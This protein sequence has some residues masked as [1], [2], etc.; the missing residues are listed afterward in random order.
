[1]AA[2]YNCYF[3]A[4]EKMLELDDKII[5]NHRDDYNYILPYFPPIDTNFTKGFKTDLDF[6]FEKSKVAL[7]KHKN[8][9]WIAE[10]Y[11]I[12][13]K[14]KWYENKLD[15]AIYVHK[16]VIAK[17]SDLVGR[18]FAQISLLR[19]YLFQNDENQADDEYLELQKQKIYPKNTLD[20]NLACIEY[21]YQKRGFEEMLPHLKSAL[22]LEKKKDQRSRLHFIIAQI[23]QRNEN[24]KIAYNEYKE[25]LKRNPPYEIEFNAKLNLSQVSDVGNKSQ[26][27]KTDKMYDK[28]IT[29]LKNQD[30]LGR[31]YYER[32]KFELK[33]GNLSKCISYLNTSL[34]APNTSNEQKAYSYLLLGQ[35]HY[36]KIDTMPTIV[37]KYS[38]AKLYYDSTVL[39][40][41]KNFE[42]SEKIRERQIILAEFVKQLTIVAD[43]ER[44]QKWAT[45]SEDELKVEVEKKMKLDKEKLERELA[46]EKKRADLAKKQ[47]S[48]SFDD[49]AAP[50][51]GKKNFFAYDQVQRESQK[52]KF[53]EVW[54]LRPLEDNWR[55]I[56]K[57]PEEEGF[58]T[59]TLESTSYDKNDSLATTDTLSKEI[60]LDA[61]SYTKSLPKDEASLAISN[62]KLQEALYQ[63]GKIY[64][65][66]LVEIDNAKESFE[67]YIK[68]FSA[69]KH[70]AEVIY[71]LY[72]I[73]QRSQACN[74]EI[75]RTLEIEK[76]PNSL[77]RKLMDDANYL[78]SNQE[79]NKESHL[80]Y[81]TAYIQY[82][83]GKYTAASQEL[84]NLKKSFPKSDILDKITFL[85]ILCYAQT[86]QIEKY[87]LELENFV[88]AFGTSP[89]KQKALEIISFKPNN[90]ASLVRSDENYT[91]NDSLPHFFVALFN[92]KQMPDTQ[93]D[94]IY[95]EFRAAYYRDITLSTKIIEFSD[96]TYLYVNKSF[97]NF[98]AG[99]QYYQ[100][101]INY[102]DFGKHLEKIDY[103]YYLVTEENYTKLLASKNINGFK[104]FYQKQYKFNK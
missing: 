15:T 29:D 99:K 80:R 5:K 57:D 81:E 18:Q 44:N 75:Y 31:I 36:E 3:L 86:D 35:L 1:M 47:E 22:A 6:V 97:A 46:Q 28:M 32:A 37:D 51:L 94:R 50:E 91:R 60:K 55:R 85:H 78:V 33:K 61:N 77:Y 56:N 59:D 87:Y 42:H 53:E 64:Y 27:H 43:E 4:K 96:S 79:E 26:T 102:H 76:Y 62:E 41:G 83:N 21:L 63:L 70:G 88:Q 25:S 52:F 67:K 98:E 69:N 9:N 38:T 40:M 11:N 93:I 73:C 89:L 19:I 54:G 66:D 95:K 14:S 30:Y 74:K 10:S 58:D 101:L 72:L 104:L 17:T 100:K 45:L 24:N 68:Q 39:N 2:R 23:N 7:D 8:S 13:A 48:N 103:S 12:I 71:F 16:Y 49:I 65:Y 90:F 84:E 20:Y 92:T 34:E 82:K